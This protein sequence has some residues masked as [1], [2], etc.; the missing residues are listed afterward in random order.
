[1]TF[2]AP[3]IRFI[4][5]VSALGREWRATQ[6][7]LRRACYYWFMKNPHAVA[8]GKLGGAKGG[9]ARSAALSSRRRQEIARV[10]GTARWQAVPFE[11]RAAIA[12]TAALVRWRRAAETLTA[13]AAPVAV[14]RLLKTYDPAALRW[15]ERD[16]R[17][18]I[19][20]EILLRGD[21]VANRW[22]RR[23]LSRLEVRS[24]IRAYAGAGCNEPDRAVLRKKLNLTVKDLPVRPF[25]G[26][27]TREAHVQGVREA[28]THYGAL[29]FSTK[30]RG[31]EVLRLE[32]A[33][34]EA[35]VLAHEDPAVAGAVPVVLW[36]NEQVD[37]GELKR[38]AVDRGEGQTL[39]FFLELTDELSRSRRF[40]TVAATLRDKRVRRRRNFFSRDGRFRPYEEELALMT[41]PEV[42][43]RWNFVMNMSL[44]SFKS[45][46]S[47]ATEP[48][49]RL[50]PS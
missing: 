10:A 17:H 33:L 4:P 23:K 12:R 19:V 5:S 30:G 11:D 14:R 1:M 22:L 38:L 7:E 50:A 39:G 36:K 6:C 41:T 25:L 3:V 15:A 9:H 34:A 37:L 8:L 21:A 26:F 27:A 18:V 48:S 20:R 13:A 32:V 2:H 42:A 44:D 31:G 28:L 24:L 43:K 49:V 29:L 45:Y 47:K 40:E 46:F 16:D 35:L